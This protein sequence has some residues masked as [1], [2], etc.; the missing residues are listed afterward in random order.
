MLIALNIRNYLEDK[1]ITQEWLAQKI[2]MSKQTMS[3]TLKGTR[4]L[5]AEE[6][7]AICAAL[8]LSMDY[9]KDTKAITR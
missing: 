9:F 1:G 8:D 6:Y 2:G 3:A 4:R 5:T 7:V